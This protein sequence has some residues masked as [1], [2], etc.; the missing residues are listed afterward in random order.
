MATRTIGPGQQHPTISDWISHLASID[1]WDEEQIGELADDV[2]DELVNFSGF[3]PTS[4]YPCTLRPVAGISH[5]G[6]FGAGARI[7]LAKSYGFLVTVDVPHMTI[8]DLVIDNTTTGNNG[9]GLTYTA[10]GTNGILQRCLIRTSGAHN[11]SNGI[12]STYDDGKILNCY[13]ESQSTHAGSHAIKA[14][15]YSKDGYVLNCIIKANAGYGLRRL[16]NSK[17]TV[18]NCVVIGSGAGLAYDWPVSSNGDGASSNNA[19]HEGATYLPPGTSPISADISVA[20]GVD[21]VSPSTMDWSAHSTGHLYGAGADQSAI[22]TD[23]LL[24]RTRSQWDISAWGI[25][26]AGTVIDGLEGSLALVAK[27]VPVT[28][29]VHVVAARGQIDLISR[30]GALGIAK[31]IGTVSGLAALVTQAIVVDGPFARRV[32]KG[33]TLF[34]RL[35]GIGMRR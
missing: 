35:A 23:D 2:F 28:V 16:N 18:A 22:F 34:G 7:V 12:D 25:A 11:L 20:D 10:N 4:A 9:R 14:F 1:P 30:M 21:F 33:M 5:G 13:V 27:A 8:E 3:T 24:G 26:V 29:A 6:T 15:Q 32:N 19:S 31:V 17:S